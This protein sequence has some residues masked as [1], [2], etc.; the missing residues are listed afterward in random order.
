MSILFTLLCLTFPVIESSCAYSNFVL[1]LQDEV[2]SD[3]LLISLEL[4][5]SLTYFLNEL[6]VL[7]Y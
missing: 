1:T 6:V 3:V 5:I 7:L 2:P 4:L